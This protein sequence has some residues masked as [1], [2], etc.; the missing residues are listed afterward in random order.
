[1]PDSGDGTFYYVLDEP[2]EILFADDDPILREF[3]QVQLAS[4]M[5]AIHLAEHGQ[6]ALDHLAAHP[7]S[8]IVLDLEMPVMDG[9]DVLAHLRANPATADIPVIVC[10]GREDVAAIDRAFQAGATSFVVK[11]INWR[12]LS[13]QIRYV[14]RANQHDALSRQDL[15]ALVKSSET[16]VRLS[17][18]G[19]IRLREAAG[20]FAE[21]LTRL[22]HRLTG[23]PGA[24]A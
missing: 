24:R 8:L 19:E 3:A 20:D 14:L 22:A 18:G 2:M 23:A 1:M 21:V 4:D 17:A 12:L 9:F 6:A 15:K 16:L 11:P 7:V 10:T 13:H 5:A